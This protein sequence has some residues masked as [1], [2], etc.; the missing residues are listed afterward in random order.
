MM[1]S[2]NGRVTLILTVNDPESSARWYAGVFNMQ[3]VS[4][5]TDPATRARNI[6][7]REPVSELDIC[8]RNDPDSSSNRFNEANIGLD[9]AEFLVEDRSDLDAW[10]RHLDALGVAHSG[11]KAPTYSPNAM[12]TLRDPDGIQLELFWVGRQTT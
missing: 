9:H 7:L 11:I 3:T 4:E 8:L 2:L 5:Y 1:P 12:I 10:V 6:F